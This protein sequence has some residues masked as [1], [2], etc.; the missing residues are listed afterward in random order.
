MEAFRKRLNQP[1]FSSLTNV[2]RKYIQYRLRAHF[3][4]C[5]AMFNAS[6][7]KR[8]IGGRCQIGETELKLPCPSPT[9]VDDTC[10]A[11]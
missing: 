4:H 2:E 11:L 3:V 6:A 10:T 9:A 5:A 8:L 1:A 7:L